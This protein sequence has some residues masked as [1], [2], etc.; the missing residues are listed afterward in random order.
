MWTP[1]K[2]CCDVTTSSS[3]LPA[4]VQLIAPKARRECGTEG[5]DARLGR[6]VTHAG[7]IKFTVGVEREFRSTGTVD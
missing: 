6:L 2:N 4:P 3:I 5:T 1:V 7:I